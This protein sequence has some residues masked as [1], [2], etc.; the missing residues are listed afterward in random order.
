MDQNTTRAFLDELEKMVWEL[1][2]TCQ[3]QLRLPSLSRRRGPWG[4]HPVATHAAAGA[5]GFGAGF[6]AGRAT[7]P[8]AAHTG[9]SMLGKGA[10]GA[11]LLGAGALGYHLL[12]RPQAAAQG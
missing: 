1:L 6:A 12:N 8:A 3:L 9:M 4:H 10:L 2:L 7:A 11:G 5:G